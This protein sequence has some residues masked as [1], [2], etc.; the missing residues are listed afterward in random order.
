M[1]LASSPRTQPSSP[2][3]ATSRPPSF[4]LLLSRTFRAVCC[5]LSRHDRGHIGS[6][7]QPP[8][9]RAFDCLCQSWLFPAETPSSDVAAFQR[10]VQAEHPIPDCTTRKGLSVTSEK[11]IVVRRMHQEM[12]SYVFL[13]L[14]RAGLIGT[15]LS[16]CP[17]N[18]RETYLPPP[19]SY[20]KCYAP[21]RPQL[22]S[23]GLLFL[24][25]DKQYTAGGSTKS[26]A[27][28]G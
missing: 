23:L 14:V 17:P 10:R 28:K 12:T 2:C 5:S 11:S 25:T 18:L 20:E 1:P 3:S 15:G 4:H 27:L 22:A 26:C 24:L 19:A 16:G 13:Y 6:W 8:V 7:L 9:R 21:G